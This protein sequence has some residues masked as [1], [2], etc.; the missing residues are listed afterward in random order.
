MVEGGDGGRFAVESLA[1]ACVARVLLGQH[2]DGNRDLKA[3]VRRPVHDAHGSAPE[4]SLNW[5]LAELCGTHP[6]PSEKSVCRWCRDSFFAQA[7]TRAPK[8]VCIYL[9][10]L[11]GI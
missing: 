4:F 2:L 5:I 11:K 7:P 9:N 1:E 8:P 10:T 3:R 6:G